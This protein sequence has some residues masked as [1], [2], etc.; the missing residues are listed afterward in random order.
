MDIAHIY[1]VTDTCDLLS[2]MRFQMQDLRTFCYYFR[3]ASKLLQKYL[4]CLNSIKE[5]TS[6][7]G[8]P[9]NL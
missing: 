2:F 3:T 5:N 1:N 8:T 7:K 6:D 9:G 4:Q